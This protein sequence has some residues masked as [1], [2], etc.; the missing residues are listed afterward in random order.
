SERGPKV[1]PWLIVDATSSASCSPRSS[2]RVRVNRSGCDGAGG[3]KGPPE[4]HDS[5]RRRSFGTAGDVGLWV[6][7]PG[8]YPGSPSDQ[9]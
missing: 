6:A 4:A 8:K 2:W 5:G 3:R 9:A 1:A 7:D